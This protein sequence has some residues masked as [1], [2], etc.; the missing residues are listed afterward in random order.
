MLRLIPKI[1]DFLGYDPFS[2][3]MQTLAERMQHYR[4]ISGFSIKKLARLLGI[5]PMTLARWE[6]GEVEPRGKLK[7]RVNLF[8]KILNG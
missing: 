1:I 2:G 3:R 8:L 4:R 7:E 5:D 6:S